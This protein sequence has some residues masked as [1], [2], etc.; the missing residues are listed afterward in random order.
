[1]LRGSDFECPYCG[2]WSDRYIWTR[3]ESGLQLIYKMIYKIYKIHA[4]MKL[5]TALNRITGRDKNGGIKGESFMGINGNMQYDLSWYNA[6][7]A[8]ALKTNPAQTAHAEKAADCRTADHQ[9][10]ESAGENAES[11]SYRQQLLDKME[12]MA[13]NIRNGTIQPKIQ[14]GARAY[15]KEEW[16]KLLREF[17]DTEEALRE[18]VEEAIA[19]AREESEKEAVAEAV[20][21]PDEEA[22]AQKEIPDNTTAAEKTT[23]VSEKETAA[24]SAQATEKAEQVREAVVSDMEFLTEEVTKCSYKT[25]ESEGKRWYITCYSKDGI[26]CKEAY[27]ENGRWVNR[28]L[29]SL[30]FTKTGQYEKVISFLER[31]E[32][33]A[34]LRFAAHEKFWR[35]FLAGKIDEDDFVASFK[36]EDYDAP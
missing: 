13:E 1:M 30:P 12:E 2:A 7:K 10:S 31:F 23:E 19:K 14:T 11:K 16:Q 22:A 29:W 4:E 9:A 17:D 27:Q 15:T 34:N 25:S 32:K 5:F 24:G 6:A 33:D 8:A 26:S 21:V 3:P 18:E 28:D 20:Q 35:D 36:E